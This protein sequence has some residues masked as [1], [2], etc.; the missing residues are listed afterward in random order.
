[1]RR[2]FPMLLWSLVFPGAV[3][4]QSILGSSGLGTR[5]EPLDAVQR[6]LGGA[7]VAIQSSTVLPG[8]PTA[9][10]DLLAS[11]LTFTIQPTWADYTVGS[12]EGDF[13]E[14]RFPVFGFAFPIGTTSVLTLTMGSKFDQ[15]WSAVVQDS[16]DLGGTMVGITDEFRSE[17]G[18]STARAGWAK[19]LTPTLAVGATAGMHMG[20]LTRSFRRTFAQTVLD[21]V[22]VAG[23]IDPFS[24]IG[25]WTHSG[26]VVSL[27]VSWDPIR[28]VQLTGAID[29]SGTIAVT[30]TDDVGR[31]TLDVDVPLEFKLAAT[32]QV[33]PALMIT[34]GMSTANWSD[35][36][37]PQI[38]SVGVGRASTIG[39]GIQWDI[40]N[41]WAGGFPLR[42]GYRR[43][44]LPFR[45]R[46]DA[47][48]ES[49]VSF[50]FAVTMFQDEGLPLA[51]FDVAWEMGGRSSGDFDENLRRL[52]VS[53]RIGGR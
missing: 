3:I 42:L 9:S 38:D 18:V 46:G 41:F 37:V 12:D 11:T 13:A 47:V 22:S 8:D 45:F 28:S 4:G 10:L 1:M 7:G 53:V 50:G 23:P 43:A 14:T 30:P 31:E 49:A 17:G 33:S 5:T 52:T 35:L 21:S 32:T 26:P 39:A 36:G 2:F 20:G 6:A 25:R 40:G 51:G 24:D 44:S 27:N 16:L 29:W 15:R 48:K 19:R 34:A